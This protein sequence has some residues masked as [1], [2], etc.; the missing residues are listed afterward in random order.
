MDLT[1]LDLAEIVVRNIAKQKEKGDIFNISFN[2][3]MTLKK[4][5]HNL[6]INK[7]VNLED[8]FS[9]YGHYNIA[10]YMT[11]INNAYVKQPNMNLFE[12]TNI[13]MFKC[14]NAYDIIDSIMIDFD[15]YIF[16]MV[17]GIKKVKSKK[18]KS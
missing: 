3:K 14:E 17:N 13:N 4:M 9:E 15:Y 18:V 7:E 16:K 2:V 11:D 12:T 5:A 10:Q 8:W 6:G 1:P